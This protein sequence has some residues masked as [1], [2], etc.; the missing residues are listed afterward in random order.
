MVV[1]VFILED[2]MGDVIGD[3]NCC[4]GMIKF[5]EIGFMGVWVKVD[6]FLSEMFGYIG[7][8]WIM[9]FGWG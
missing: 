3:L 9:I 6:V 1:D 8:L 5:Q 7:D 4:W 2:Y